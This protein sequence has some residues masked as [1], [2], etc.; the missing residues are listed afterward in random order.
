MDWMRPPTTKPKMKMKSRAEIQ[1]AIKAWIGT[2]AMR[3]ISRRT[4]VPSPIQLMP[5][6]AC[7]GRDMVG[8][9]PG[10]DQIGLFQPA[11]AGHHFVLAAFAHDLAAGDD[12]DVAAKPLHLFQIVRGQQDGAAV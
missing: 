6:G 1:G 4:M 7:S 12:G 3:E 8:L 10:G 11:G 2:R 5:M 9:R